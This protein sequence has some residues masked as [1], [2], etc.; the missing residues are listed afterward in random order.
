M[1]GLGPGG[2]AI[3]FCAL[4]SVKNSE[5]GVAPCFLTL[6][7][8]PFPNFYDAAMTVNRMTICRM[9]GGQ[10]VISTVVLSVDMDILIGQ[11]I[12]CVASI[13]I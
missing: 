6:R 9:T 3:F 12:L 10:S 4:I 13:D 8:W 2:L 5:R 1:L 7:E 11:W